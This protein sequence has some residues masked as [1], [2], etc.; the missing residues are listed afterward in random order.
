MQSTRNRTSFVKCCI[1][2]QERVMLHLV[3]SCKPKLIEG[4]SCATVILIRV[5]VAEIQLRRDL[6]QGRGKRFCVFSNLRP[7]AGN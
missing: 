7:K 5:R 4:W 6:A 2:Q 1:P 3:Y